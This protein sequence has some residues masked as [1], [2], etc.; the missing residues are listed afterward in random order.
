MRMKAA[1]LVEVIEPEMVLFSMSSEAPLGTTMD[2]VIWALRM[3]VDPGPSV[4][5]V[6]LP[7]TVVVQVTFTGADVVELD[8]LKLA[9]PL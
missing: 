1:P 3:H 7:V 8:G 9:S 2:P 4:R 6:W 5:P